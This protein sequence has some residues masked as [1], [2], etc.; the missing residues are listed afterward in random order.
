MR[1]AQPLSSTVQISPSALWAVDVESPCRFKTPGWAHSLWV[2]SMR[3]CRA[4]NS[5]E[6][7]S[8][9]SIISI[10][11]LI[12]LRWNRNKTCKRPKF[13][14]I[15]VEKHQG[16]VP[17]W[18]IQSLWSTGFGWPIRRFISAV[19]VIWVH[20]KISGRGSPWRAG[21]SWLSEETTKLKIQRDK[22]KKRFQ[23]TKFP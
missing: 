14:G 18:I 22:A 9:H 19:Q 21:N 10:H 8:D 5:V 20:S 2:N 11:L 12:S 13:N 4:F 23:L 16:W 7:D 3:N 1:G 15:K 6:T 17:A